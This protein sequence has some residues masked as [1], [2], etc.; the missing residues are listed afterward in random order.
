[1]TRTPPTVRPRA[2]H[3]LMLTL[4]TFNGAGALAADHALTSLL[5]WSAFA[6]R[7]RIA[8]L[9]FIAAMFVFAFSLIFLPTPI[10]RE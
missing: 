7:A 1:M 2:R 10:D 4:M 9:P 3:P 6:E 5:G 8:T